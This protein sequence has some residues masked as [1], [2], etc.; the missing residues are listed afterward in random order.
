VDIFWPDVL[1]FLSIAAFIN[2]FEMTLRVIFISG[3]HAEGYWTNEDLTEQLRGVILLFE[4]LHKGCI[5]IFAFD[6]SL[7]Y[8]ATG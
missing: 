5:G 6:L 8:K 7:N 3:Q 2:G 1:F 4:E